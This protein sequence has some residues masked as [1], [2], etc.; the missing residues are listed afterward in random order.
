MWRNRYTR[1]FEGRVERSLRVQV[2]PS[3]IKKSPL[4]LFFI[5]DKRMQNPNAKHFPGSA[6]LRT[7]GVKQV[8]IANRMS[9]LSRKAQKRNSVSVEQIQDKSRHRHHKSEV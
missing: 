3:T 6:D 4:G 9:C 8:R 7:D 1:T 5:G 2:P